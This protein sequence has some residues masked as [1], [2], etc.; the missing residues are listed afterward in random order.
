MAATFGSASQAGGVYTSTPATRPAAMREL[1]K[2]EPSPAWWYIHH[3]A[4]WTFRDGEWLPWLSQLH[5]DPGV[6]NV[7]KNGAMDMAEVVKRR[8]GWTLIP[9]DAEP[10]G[11]CVVYDG[12]AGQV[13]LSKWQ[14]PKLV[15]GQTR[16]ESD[17]AGYWEFCR[18]LVADGY[19]QLPDPDFLLVQIDRQEKKVQE[20]REKAPTS[21]YH[22]DALAVEEA[23]LESMIAGKERLYSPASDDALSVEAPGAPPPKPR[24][25]GRA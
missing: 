15:A 23:L 3:P 19:I 6:A 7:D 11:Y 8:Q 5:A 25:G 22:R 17:E 18:R 20:W 21:P 4:R 10:G 2:L 13:H 14:R 24:R 1:V 9:W 12:V 16:I